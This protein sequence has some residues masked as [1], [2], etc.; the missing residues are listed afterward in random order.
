[1][2]PAPTTSI[3]LLAPGA[4]DTEAEDWGGAPPAPSGYEPLGDPVRAHLSVPRGN[5][6]VSPGASTSNT[7][8]FLICDPCAM[9]PDMLIH[10]LITGLDWQVDWAVYRPDPFG[11]DHIEARIARVVASP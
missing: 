6:S 8:V 9:A 1:M 4:N 5:T 11:L 2:I 10:D 7:D 3:Q